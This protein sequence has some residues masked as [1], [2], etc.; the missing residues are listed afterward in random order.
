MSQTPPG[1]VGAAAEDRAAEFLRAQGLRLLER[2]FRCRLG[3][4]D[5]IMQDGPELVFV[6]VRSR[7]HPDYGSAVETI[8]PR[9][10]QRVVRAAALY[11]QRHPAAARAN[12]RFD[13]VAMDGHRLQW[14][15]GAFVAAE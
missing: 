11:L 1:H 4:I 3:E 15:R 10:R 2:N 12:C 13:V 7:S 14:I 6:E 9:K 5:L 8:G